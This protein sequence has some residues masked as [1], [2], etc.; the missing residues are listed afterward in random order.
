MDT[1]WRDELKEATENGNVLTSELK[2][3]RNASKSDATQ[4]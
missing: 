4:K 2:V 3:I 1:E